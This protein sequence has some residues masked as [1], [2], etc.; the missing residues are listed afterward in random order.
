[1]HQNRGPASSSWKNSTDSL[2]KP[3][4]FDG[5]GKR[6]YTH[7]EKD[8]GLTELDEGLAYSGGGACQCQEKN[9]NPARQSH[10]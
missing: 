4:P 10:G 3:D 8:H 9:H 7:Q 2:G 5:D 1:M 6:E